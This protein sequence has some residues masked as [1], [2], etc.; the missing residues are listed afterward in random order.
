MNNL[1]LDLIR[2]LA[3]YHFS[4]VA[5][6]CDI[7]NTFPHKNFELIKQHGLQ[8]L[9][10]PE[11]YGG[12]GL[13]FA[14]YQIFLTEMARGCA[15]TASAFNMHNIVV[16]SLVDIFKAPME[17]S[18]RERIM[19]YLEKYFLE[20]VRDKKIFAA[21]TTEQGIGARFS[22][23]R[24]HFKRQENGYILNGKKTFVTMADYAD[25]YLV[26]TNQFEKLDSQDTS[27]IT[28]FV[29]PRD[30]QGVYI[31]ETWDTMGMRATKSQ[32]VVFNNVFLEHSAIFMGR[33]GF[34]LSKVMRE[35]H[36]ITGGYLGVYLGVMEAA[37]RF[38]CVFLQERSDN[39]LKKGLAFQPLVQARLGEMFTIL[40]SA[41]LA[42]RE[43][44]IAVDSNPR[45][46]T[47]RQAI[48]AAKYI[49]GES[50]TSLTLL[51]IKT[52]GGSSIHKQ[53]D[54]ERYH[55]DG[56]CGMLMPA[57]S[58]LCQLYL[59]QSALQIDDKCI[60]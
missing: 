58:D 38:T 39:K 27:S 24:T 49:V 10:I 4:V 31:N 43:A 48:Y 41:R 18:Q 6:E 7:N 59:G 2:E 11:E 9:L 13:S 60:W 17:N 33:E 51:A 21:A 37:Y 25:Y 34:A 44:A 42:V 23:V 16:G 32:E 40:H 30:A 55:R 57:V 22:L 5:R 50:I 8:A 46:E 28:Y 12:Y 54:L 14:E 36:W 47:T 26:L 29:V 56:C 15:A 19:P 35:P 3:E 20:V 53:F 52:C 45:D 1:L